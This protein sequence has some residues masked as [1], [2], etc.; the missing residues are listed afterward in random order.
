MN[1]RILGIIIVIVALAIIAGIVYVIFF[2]KFSNST[3]EPIVEQPAAGQQNTTLQPTSGQTDK[4]TSTSQTITQVKKAEI[5]ADDLV[6]MASAFAE[7]FGSFS[8]QSDYGNIR[9]L[10]IFMTEKMKEWAENYISD[11]RVKKT[12]TTIYYGII[13]KALSGQAKKF[14]SDIGQ[15]E[16]LVKTQRRESSGTSGNSLTFYQDILIKYIREQGVWRVDSV[17]WQ[18]R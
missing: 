7:R 2:Y 8:N 9:D 15:A 16:I 1:K 14:D 18:A 11:A 17:E 13:T 3:E 6:R 10:Q 12:Q 5:Q 4:A